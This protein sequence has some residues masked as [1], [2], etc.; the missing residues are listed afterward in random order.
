MSENM[1]QD[2][3]EMLQRDVIRVQL[4][5]EL[6]AALNDL[7]IERMDGQDILYMSVSSR[8]YFFHRIRIRI[9]FDSSVSD[10]YEYE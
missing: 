6:E 7:R 8:I 4:T 1:L 9:I 5:T 2:N 3:E 10:E